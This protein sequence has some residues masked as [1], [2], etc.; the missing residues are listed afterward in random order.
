M[1]GKRKRLKPGCIVLPLAISLWGCS[2]T[3]TILIDDSTNFKRHEQLEMVPESS[4]RDTN[5]ELY[6]DREGGG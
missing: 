4:G 6:M 5:Q 1:H 3:P 2:Q